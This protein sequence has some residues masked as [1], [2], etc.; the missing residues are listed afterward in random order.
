LAAA[1]QT[2][3]KSTATKRNWQ[4]SFTDSS[5]H[6]GEVNPRQFSSSFSFARR[7]LEM[8]PRL[9][10]LMC[11]LTLLGATASS[12]QES[13]SAQQ[14]DLKTYEWQLQ[15][16]YSG[17]IVKTLDFTNNALSDEQAAAFVQNKLAVWGQQLDKQGIRYDRLSARLIRKT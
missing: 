8:V 10:H 5:Y 4:P 13:A 14:K 17:K 16:F 7:E 9:I 1:S 2:A 6:F 12:V 11:V 3:A 15:A